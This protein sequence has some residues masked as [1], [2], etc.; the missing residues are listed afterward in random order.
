MNGAAKTMRIPIITPLKTGN[1]S[2]KMGFM[3][4]FSVV[5]LLILTAD[6]PPLDKYK[7]KHRTA[8]LGDRKTWHGQTA[9]QFSDDCRII[10]IADLEAIGRDGAGRAAITP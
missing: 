2:I 5:W 6:P 7:L 3:A 10:G 9:F 1:Y 8:H 4:Q